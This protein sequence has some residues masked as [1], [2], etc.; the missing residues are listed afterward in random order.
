MSKIVIEGGYPLCGVIDIQGAKN[1]IL[2]ILAA[3]F[4]ADGECVID[5]CP[6][7]S[8]THAAIKILR[9]LGSTVTIH[10]NTV[11]INSDYACGFE[12][13]DELMRKMRSSIMFL[14]AILGK[15]KRA[16]VSFPGGCELGPR[17]ID[18]H[19]SALA[20]MGVTIREEFG[21]LDCECREIK[22]AVIDLSFPS[23]GATENIMLA[24][25]KADGVT[26]INNAAKEPE[27]EDLQ[28][29]LVK[30]GAKI[31]GAGSGKIIIEGVKKLIG[32]RHSVIPDRI[33][34]ATYLCAVAA[35]GGNALLKNAN[36]SH[37]G[38]LLS[39]LRES[40]CEIEVYDD[41]IQVACDSLKG[42]HTVRT[43]PFPGFATDAQAVCM[44]LMCKAKG[45][46]VFIETIFES[47]FKQVGELLRMGAKITTEG[48]V[49]VVEG[50]K[51]LYGTTVEAGDLR[52]GASLVVA[53]LS[54]EGKTVVD[55]AEH[56]YRGYE[57]IE[58]NLLDLGARVS[59]EK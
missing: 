23:V 48:R 39:F 4:L 18:L 53:G 38:T 56:I 36:A 44:A 20:K 29:F 46:T 24:A 57:N 26:V 5:N 21:Y 37:L 34:T 28:N 25:V 19:I 15:K 12:I 17:P 43:M 52:G 50:V 11:Y 10:G 7:I 13:P 8:D 33:V 22:G 14:G 58:K 45:S 9:A 6:D 32:A 41:S 47:R 40:G 35:T 59:I 54:A 2:P 27:I 1:S 42:G 16:L 51:K 3:A 31:S 30:M 55:N 49:A